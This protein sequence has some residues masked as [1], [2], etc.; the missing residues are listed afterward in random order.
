ML[1]FS[2][3]SY[4]YYPPTTNDLLIF[5]FQQ[6]NR[7]IHL[8]GSDNRIKG[9]TLTN[10]YVI[11]PFRKK[12]NCRILFLPNHSTHSDPQMMFEAQRR[13]G[14]R[15]MY[16][17]AYDG[18]L[19]SKVKGWVMQNIGAFS[20]DREASDS[21]SI[22]QAV[23]SLKD[24]KYAMTIFPEGNVYLMNDR[25]TP[26]LEG[27]SFIAMKAQKVLGPDIPIYAFPISMKV[28]HLNDQRNTIKE[29]INFLV[30]ESGLE[31][32][33]TD[34][35]ACILKQAGITLVIK[36]L[37]QRGYSPPENSDE[38]IPDF[39]KN[40]AEIIISKLEQKIEITPKPKDDLIERIKKVRCKI[41]Q[42]RIDKEKELTHN[43]ASTWADEAILAFRI[44]S[45]TGLYLDESPT[46]DRYG[47]VTEKLL[48]DLHSKL[49]APYA[50]RHSFI[51]FNEPLPLNEYLD[52]FKTNSRET[53]K[54]ITQK[55]E[56]SVQEGIDKINSNNTYPGSK[57]FN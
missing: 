5:I 16:M 35:L 7:F 43:V 34:S 39:L 25:I 48:E 27:A 44:L 57:L 10:E 21:Q 1:N 13:I 46:I 15:S 45:Y 11:K 8:P 14:I 33:E 38:N 56:N 29:K 55:V 6:F 12:K 50:D 26:F 47:E 52:N 22:K 36:N 49:I 40:A 28:T 41:H 32:K 54:E 17:A 37:K 31:I 42:I 20:V 24:G 18:F 19:E 51:H 2:D 53:L 30:K 23:K 9:L 3:K 4:Q